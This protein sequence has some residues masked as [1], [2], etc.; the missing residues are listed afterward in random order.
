[1]RTADIVRLRDI[2]RQTAAQHLRELVGAGRLT[3]VGSTHNARYLAARKKGYGG[4]GRW[5]F[6]A[7][8]RTAALDEDEVFSEAALRLN[9]KRRLSPAAYRIVNYAFTEMTNNAIEHSRAPSVRVAVECSGGDLRFEVV[10]HGIGAFESV[11]K[12]FRLNDHLEAVELLMK[13]KQTTDPRHHSGQGI[14][15]TSRIADRFALESARLK[16][17]VDHRAKD[18]FLEDVRV[19]RGTR[20]LFTLKQRS[21][22]DLRTLFDEYSNED[23]EFDKTE[24]VVHLSKKEGDYVSRSEAKRLLFGLERF[25]RIVFDFR[26]VTGIGQGFA[27]E[28]FRVFQGQHPGLRIEV[29]HMSDAVEF[30]I[31]RA[32]RG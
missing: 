12:K 29:V 5:R 22:K 6:S 28:I 16:L 32:Q 4:Q 21:R 1:V 31:R 14:F 3:K 26:R 23:Y 19:F 8:H 24:I 13:G 30:M 10:D 2:S 27:D 18:T 11:R 15:F 17:I 25:R 9:L 7:L 20:V